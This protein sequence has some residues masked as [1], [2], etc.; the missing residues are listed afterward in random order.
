M[1]EL[2]KH[3][4][5][6]HNGLRYTLVGDYYIPDLELPEETLP[7]G[8]WGRM[9]KDYLEQYHPAQYNDLI[10]SGKLWAYLS[11]LNEQAQNRLEGIIGQMKE[12]EGITEKLKTQDQMS[13]VRAMNSIRSR[14]EEIILRELIYKEDAV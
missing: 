14:A 1:E 2:K 4:Y 7:I 12:S 8:I 13:W 6:E 10:L 9:H 5:D 11:D 3:I